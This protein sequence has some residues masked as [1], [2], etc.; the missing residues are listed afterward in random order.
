M[1]Y[2]LTHPMIFDVLVVHHRAFGSELDAEDFREIN[3]EYRDF[4]IWPE[5]TLSKWEG[6]IIKVPFRNR[7]N[8]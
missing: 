5:E 4:D 1:K 8:D 6:S 7:R 3:E 2:F